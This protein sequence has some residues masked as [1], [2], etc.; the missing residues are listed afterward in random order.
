MSFVYSVQGQTKAFPSAEGYGKYAS[1]GRGGEVVE[2]TNLQDYAEGE[3]PIEGSFRWAFTQEKDS[4]QNRWGVWQYFWKPITVVF[5]VGGVIQLKRELRVERDNMTIAGQT[6]PGD[7][8][9]FGG[10][11]LNFSA[12]N[13]VIVRY[14]R[15]RPGDELGEETSA[16]RI[17]NGGDFIID[18]CSFSWG[19]EETTHFSSD[20]NLTVQWCIISE[21]LYNS[22][23]KKG[24]RGYAAQWGG[25]YATYHHNLL[26]DHQSRMPRINGSNENDVYALIDYRNNVNFNWGSTGAF[27]G[28]EWEATGGKGYS[29]V[30]VVNNYFIPG[31]GT[32]SD[33]YFARPSLNRDGRQLDGYAQWYFDG[34]VMVGSESK[35]TDNWLGVDPTY[36]HYLDSIRSDEEFVKTNGTLEAYVEYTQSADNAYQSVMDY[37]GA[38]LPKRD[39]IDA[40]V[41]AEAKGEIDIVRYAYTDTSGQETPLRGVD[42]GIIDTQRNLV[43][44][45]APVGTTAWDVYSSSTDA[46]ADSDHDG[47][48]DSWEDNHGLNKNDKSDGPEITD[49]GYS[50]LEIYLNS[51]DVISTGVSSIQTK[52]EDFKVYPNPVSEQIYLQCSKKITNVEVFDLFGKRIKVISNS[53]GIKSIEASE[54]ASGV[55]LIK[56]TSSDQHDFYQKI[57]KQ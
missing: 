11:T 34:N 9:C 48:P 56:A 44:N 17:E 39:T 6:A 3:T 22:I 51:M 10:G 33:I 50:N 43:P 57:V 42:T 1:G 35:T 20:T 53:G 55:Y 23:H 54:L 7:G 47:M 32:S 8:I 16:F 36:V 25:Q 38:I 21:S 46:P 29:H 49:S 24:P 41:I 52:S 5:R 28:G 15:S 12:S 30:N 37:V 4:A 19:I 27:Y 45:D 13:N 26:A 40:R 2:V 18:H 31:P 14:I